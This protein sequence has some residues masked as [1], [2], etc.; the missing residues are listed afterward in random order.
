VP[1][2]PYNRCHGQRINEQCLPTTHK[3]RG[4]WPLE[5]RF[6]VTRIFTSL[7]LFALVSMLVALGLGLYV[8]SVNAARVPELLSWHRAHFL[9]GV[10]AS[11]VVVLVNCISM[12]YFI[13]TSRWCKEVV[14]T[15]ELDQQLVRRSTTLKRQTFPWALLSVLTMVGV[16]SLGAAADIRAPGADQWVTYHL[17]GAL[18]G[19]SFIA[20][21]F[22]M[23]VQRIAAHHAV[24]GEIMQEVRRIRIERGLESASASEESANR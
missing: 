15:Y 21:S 3:S 22:Y 4:N 12:T 8:T 10:F 7:A 11:L 5:G 2:C 1:K 9:S 6:T 23:Q 24:I 14:D 16:S 19:F 18:A 17:V 20:L 13:G